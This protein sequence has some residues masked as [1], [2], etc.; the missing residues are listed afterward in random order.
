MFVNVMINIEYIIPH[1]KDNE[2]IWSVTKIPPKT[3][4]CKQKQKKAKK[5]PHAKFSKKT[6]KKK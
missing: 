4:T 6:R 5:T 2:N 3:R 1:T